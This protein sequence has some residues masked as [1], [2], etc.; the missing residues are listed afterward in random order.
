M[1]FAGALLCVALATGGAPWPEAD[2]AT[3]GVDAATLRTV[4]DQVRA[5]S[6]VK[7]TSVLVARNGTLLFERYFGDAGPD[8]LL[9]TRSATKTLTGYLVGA[10]IDRKLL[11]GVG[12]R[13]TPHFKDRQPFAHP[14]PRKD[15]IKVED[16]LT[17][18]SPLEC[19][20]WNQF[21]RGNE[22]RMYLIED[23]PR[24]FLDL[25]IR[26][27]PSFATRPED[28]RYGRSFSYCTAGVSTLGFLLE[29]AVRMPLDRFADE[30]LFRKLGIERIQ[31]ARSPQGTVQTG[32]GLRLRARD[33]L[34]LAQLALDRG[35]W[36]GVRVLD[37]AWV[38]ESIRP[39]AQIDA[40]TEYGY[41]WWLKDLAWRERKVHVVYMSGNGGNKVGFVPELD[42]AFAITSDNYGSKGM[43]EQTER[44]LVK[45]V[46]AAVRP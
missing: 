22:E 28:S 6:L 43:H 8:T 46:L 2:P 40:Q 23:W 45:S 25:P 4:E 24:F 26:G 38:A 13:V 32:G 7:L 39:H 10:A 34:A 31:W 19:D 18:S 21:S 3:A 16:L 12:A 14:D 11:S 44:V 36:R 20:D 42:V 15:R 5:G 33:L 41:L 30:M 9:D 27:F 35:R 1:P 29:R 17:M 37:P